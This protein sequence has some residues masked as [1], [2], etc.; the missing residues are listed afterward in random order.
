MSKEKHVDYD[1]I[2]VVVPC[3]DLDEID[4]KVAHL[5]KVLGSSSMNRSKFLVQCALKE[6]V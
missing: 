5:R 3:G 2:S 6:A 4:R 1:V